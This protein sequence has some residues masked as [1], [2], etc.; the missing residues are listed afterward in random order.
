[1]PKNIIVALQAVKLYR[2][3]FVASQTHQNTEIV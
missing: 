2:V 1:M 3:R